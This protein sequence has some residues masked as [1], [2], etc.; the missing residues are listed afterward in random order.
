MRLRGT[1]TAFTDARGR[2]TILANS[3]IEHGIQQKSSCMTCHSRATV[4]LRSARPGMPGWQANT[5]PLDLAVRTV[6]DEAVGVP[7]P[8]WFVDDY[9]ER[10]YLQTHFLWSPPFRALSA[11]VSPP[12]C[13]RQAARQ[14]RGVSPCAFESGCS[15]SPSG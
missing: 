2:P 15:E 8:A 13:P 14:S 3:Q 5:L 10:T 11:E 1:Q 12:E 6:L 9:N 7:D 4:G